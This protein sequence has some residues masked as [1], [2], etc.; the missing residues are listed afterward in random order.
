MSLAARAADIGL[1]LSPYDAHV[2]YSYS[3]KALACYAEGDYEPASEWARRAFALNPRF[4]ANLRFLAASLA[5]TGK[6]DVSREAAQALLRIDPN[7]SADRFAA[8]HAFKDPEK[9]R[10]FGEHLVKAGLPA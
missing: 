10:L 9:R 4:T 5:A 8:G 7:F 3:I 2:F 6:N 1:R